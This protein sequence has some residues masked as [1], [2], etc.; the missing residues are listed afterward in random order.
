MAIK[1][2]KTMARYKVIITTLQVS[3]LVATALQ[4]AKFNKSG[5]QYRP[6]ISIV[7]ATW[8]GLSLALAVHM[9]TSWTSEACYWKFAI[10]IASFGLVY[11]C[12]GNVAE[13]GRKLR[14]HSGRLMSFVL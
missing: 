11:W 14:K 12:R 7:A 8:A 13:L 6:V 1:T 2:H 3:L 4:I 10:T 5:L 9:M